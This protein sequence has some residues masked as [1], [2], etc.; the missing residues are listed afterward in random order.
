MTR[1]T[2]SS[3]QAQ[4]RRNSDEPKSDVA[5]PPG[6]CQCLLW[7]LGRTSPSL[8]APLWVK[9]MRQQR[10]AAAGLQNL[11]HAFGDNP[12]FNSRKVCQIFIKPALASKDLSTGATALVSTSGLSSITAW[13][14]RVQTMLLSPSGPHGRREKRTSLKGIPWEFKL[15]IKCLAALLTQ[16]YCSRHKIQCEIQLGCWKP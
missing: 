7:M 9:L 3:E 12:I 8:A 14:L 6:L 16:A 4:L 15:S 1:P 5:G 10:L 11:L 13:A 2:T